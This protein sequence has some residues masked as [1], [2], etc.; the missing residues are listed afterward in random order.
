MNCP[1]SYR[2]SI[3]RRDFLRNTSVLAATSFTGLLTGNAFAVSTTDKK[4]P[5]GVDT[6]QIINYNPEISYRRL[7]KTNLMLSEISLGG[8]WSNR[9]GGR[10]WVDY[11]H[12]EVPADVTKNRD[13]VVSRAIERGINYMDPVTSAEL[14]AY[15]KV[16]KGRRHHMH[17]AASSH[18]YNP[19]R[20]QNCTLDN[21]MANIEDSLRQ[22]Q[23]DYV[24]IWRPMFRQDGKHSDNDLEICI[25]AFEKAHQQGKA[26]FLGMSS[27]NRSFHRH[28]IENYPQFSMIIFPYTAM[29]KTRPK[30]LKSI[31]PTQIREIGSGYDASS[32]DDKTSIFEVAKQKDVGIVTI[33]PFGG[34]SLF[35][36]KISFDN[37]MTTEA[38]D[39]RARLTLAYILTNENISATIP[40]MTTIEQIDNN[41]RGSEERH[42][43]LD[44][45]GIMKFQMAVAEMR[46]RLPADYQWLHQW[47]WV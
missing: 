16:L 5:H 22:L 13:A 30:D 46:H 33:K 1:Y 41:L 39:E 37:T 35:R 17:I 34:G 15:G 45:P 43:L 27:H 4:I 44:E 28:V 9:E 25:E 20:G 29:S 6:S 32:G 3:S 38:D 42:A 7:G 2:K 19:W 40:G 47:E 26:R 21:Q 23:T 14:M 10:Y 24:D 11:A 31:D 12:G 18:T 36:S 8:H